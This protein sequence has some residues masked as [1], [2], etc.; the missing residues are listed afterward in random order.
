[1]K[2]D[3]W[4]PNSTDHVCSGHFENKCLHCYTPT[5]ILKEEL[6]DVVPAVL[7]CCRILERGHTC[8]LW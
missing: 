2:R 5:V 1:M 4:F 8:L 7:N 3:K 6:E